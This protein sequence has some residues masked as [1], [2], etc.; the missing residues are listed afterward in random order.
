MKT[1]TQHYALGLMILCAISP[2]VWAGN[3][4]IPNSFSAGTPAVAEEVNAN[5]TAVETA[6]DDNNSRIAALETTITTLQGTLNSLK[7]A[8]AGKA[9]VTHSHK[10]TYAPAAHS[11]DQSDISQLS[12]ALGTHTSQINAINNSNVM[13]LDPYLTVSTTGGAKARLSSI[14]LQI[15]NGLGNTRTINGLGNLIVGYD[16][17]NNSSYVSNCSHGGLPSQITCEA[18]GEIWSHSHKT[19]S[20]NLVLGDSNS[21]SQYGGIVAGER[22]FVNRP[23]SGVLGGIFNTASGTYSTVSGGYRN[24]ASN[25]ASSVSAGIHNTASGENSSVS[26]GINNIASGQYSTVSG[27]GAM[28]IGH[29]STG[30]SDWRAGFLFEEQ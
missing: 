30:I 23:Y 29:E 21:Y 5:F 14:N 20:H 9:S 16:I 13:D 8:L 6:V 15:V 10:G 11:H 12:S 2:A 1:F 22:N 25:S 3:A 19:G 17:T 27:G 7:T 28:N 4:T 24:R 26:G 18:N